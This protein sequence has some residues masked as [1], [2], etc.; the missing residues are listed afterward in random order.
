[1]TRGILL[2]NLGTP[3]STETRD[4]RKYLAEFLMDPHVVDLPWPL[5]ALLVYGAILPRRPGRSA[6]AYRSIW[7]AAGPGTGSPLKHFSQGL[8]HALEQRTDMPCELAMRYGE[9]ALDSALQALAAKGVTRTL[10]VPLYPQH[11]ASTRTTTIEATRRQLPSGMTL[12]ILPPF[13]NH[14][15]YIQAQADLIRRHLPAE[16]DHLLLS[17]HGLPE[18]HLTRA[19][20]TG[21]HCLKTADCCER[22]SVAHATCYRHQ[23]RRTSDALISAIGLDASRVTTSFQ[24]RL[25]RA[26]WLTPYTDATLQALAGQ[27]VRKLVVA[28]P[29]FVAD[30]LETLEEIGIAGREQFLAA[31]GE[32]FTLVPCLNDD[33][34]W[35]SALSAWC[36]DRPEAVALRQD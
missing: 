34:A 29:A 12:E 19:D 31:G 26:A 23:V 25:G 33:E 4:V 13:F 11:A 7:D 32:S 6:A 35:I 1:M 22:P 17:Y 9:P 36:L 20:P 5:R 15:D 30:N 18:R 16:W 14:P 3:A 27:G 21:A 10:L 28:C 24:S 2:V 8:R